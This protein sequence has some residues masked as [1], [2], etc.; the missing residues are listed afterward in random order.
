MSETDDLIRVRHMLDAACKAIEFTAESKRDDL[1]KDDKLAL[2]VV[3]LLEIIGEAANNV[4]D[5]FQEEHHQIPWRLIGATRNRLIHGYF[6][7]DLD[8]VWEIV[9]SDLPMLVSQLK[10]ILQ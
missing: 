9:R 10:T 5:E 1:D 7:V 4:S 8:V 3:R 6:D 2:S